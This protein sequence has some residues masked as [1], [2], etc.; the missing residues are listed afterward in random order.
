MK[1][2]NATPDESDYLIEI[3]C[4][5]KKHWG[6]DDELIELWRDA[7]EINA[8]YIRN[9]KVVVFSVDDVEIGFFGIK[10]NEKEL[11]QFWI[12]REWIGCGHGREAF[13]QVKSIMK[14]N[15]IDLLKFDADPNASGFYE[16][17]G[18]KRIGEIESI[19]KGRFIPLFEFTLESEY[20]V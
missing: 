17:M 6:Y 2:R 18:A 8:E 15:N 19:P 10:I 12:R 4:D 9:N 3:F 11:G 5:S 16:R 1:F 7:I 13:E 20:Q 14:E